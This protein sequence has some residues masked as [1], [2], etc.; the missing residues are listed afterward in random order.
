MDWKDIPR[1]WKTSFV[2]CVI[3][4]SYLLLQMWNA[5]RG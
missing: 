4:M 1:E 2:I 3:E 5:I